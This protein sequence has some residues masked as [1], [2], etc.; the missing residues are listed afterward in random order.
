MDTTG[1]SACRLGGNRERLGRL[2][3]LRLDDHV[4][5]SHLIRHVL[6]RQV[7]ILDYVNPF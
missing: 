6:L 2:R 7:A 4:K 1:G 3:R 5:V